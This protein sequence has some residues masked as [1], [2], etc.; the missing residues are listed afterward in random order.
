MTYWRLQLK[1]MKIGIIGKL[2]AGKTFAAQ[3]LIDVYGFQRISLATPIKHIMAEYLGVYDKTDPRY[4]KLVQKV[5]TD[6]FRSEEPDV[7]INYMIKTVQENPDINY[8]CDDVRFLNEATKLIKDGW[9]L[10]YLK[11]DDEIRIERCKKRD[12]T[13]DYNTLNHPSETGV[14][15]IIAKF[16]NDVIFIDSN[17][18]IENTNKQL[19]DI[20]NFFEYQIVR[21]T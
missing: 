3:Y 6:W 7:W 19:D 13:F 11:C 2:G 16:T 5:G 8:V 1:Q 4:R 14:D 15:D 12:G 18:S 9:L 21:P 20:M 17:G 10:I